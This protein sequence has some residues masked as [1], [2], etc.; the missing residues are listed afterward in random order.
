MP[1]SRNENSV[2]V[3]N[4]EMDGKRRLLEAGAVAALKKQKLDESEEDDSDV[5]AGLERFRKAAIW[6]EMNEYK[7]KEAR[8]QVLIDT[9]ESTKSKANARLSVVDVSWGQLVAEA[10]LLLPSTSSLDTGRAGSSVIGIHLR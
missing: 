1:E 5:D 4:C 9:L 3:L 7:R 6:R 10:Q 8:A 2:L